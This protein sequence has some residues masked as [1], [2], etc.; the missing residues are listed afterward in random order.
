MSDGGFIRHGA[1]RAPA[2]PR[3]GRASPYPM[4][5]LAPPHDMVDVAREIQ[6]ADALLGAV[7][8]GRLELI[9]RQ[10][11]A[12]QAEA[13]EL[14]DA[15]RRDG[16]LHRAQCAFKKRPGR[17]YHLYRRPDG[18]RYL[19]M[20]SPEEWGG[21]PPHPFDGSYRLE[22]DMSWTPADQ[23]E[24]RDAG[25]WGAGREPAP[26]VTDEAAQLA[27]LLGRGG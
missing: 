23:I 4:S 2:G 20:L 25:I 12:L 3:E 1:G 10:I 11:R 6:Q 24:A 17:V 7:T 15:A 5:R 26:H 13:R 16:E 27:R 9:A 22:V 21:A 18:T 14:L 8:G 19:S